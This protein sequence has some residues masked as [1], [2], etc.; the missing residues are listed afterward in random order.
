MAQRGYGYNPNAK[1]NDAISEIQR[2]LDELGLG[3]GERT[4]RNHLNAAK[5]F[6]TAKPI[7][8]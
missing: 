6:L 4:I 8:T 5:A 7:K 3:L 2:D 1:K